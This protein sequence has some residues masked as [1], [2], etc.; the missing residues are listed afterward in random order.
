MNASK[1]QI[2]DFAKE[3][4][5]VS[6]SFLALSGMK[7][8]TARQYLSSLAK[9]NE[10]IRVAQGEYALPDKQ[11][12]RSMPVS[13]QNFRLQTSAST[14]AVFSPLSSITYLLIKPFMLKPTEMPLSQCLHG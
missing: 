14:T 1:R 5:R 4:Q 8:A 10:L 12:K 9:D 7:P 13:N 3:N 6:V 2:L 11:S